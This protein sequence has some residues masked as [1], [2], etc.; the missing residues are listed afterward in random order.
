VMMTIKKSNENRNLRQ[1]QTADEQRPNSLEKKRRV[2]VC[3]DG[4][5]AGASTQSLIGFSVERVVQG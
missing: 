1:Q 4:G 2:V 3:V 5:R